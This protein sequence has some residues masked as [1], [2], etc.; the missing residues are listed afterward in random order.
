MKGLPVDVLHVFADGRAT[1]RVKLA[2]LVPMVDASGPDMARG[3]TVTLLN[4]LCVLAPAALV[5]ADIRWEVLGTDRVLGTWTLGEHSVAA[6]L[7]FDAAGDLADFVSDDRLRSSPDGSSF[8]GQ[9]WSTPIRAYAVRGGR[10]VAVTGEAH[11]H[12]PEPEGTFSYLEFEV[13][14]LSYREETR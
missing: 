3:E 13:D 8:V 11:W 6:E 5:D 14:D 12:A 7:T 1:M 2:S 10:R 9:R 4:D